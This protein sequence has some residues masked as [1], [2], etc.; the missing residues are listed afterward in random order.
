MKEH[1]DNSAE[2]VT[3]ISEVTDKMHG[4]LMD[5][6]DALM[7]C[8]EGSPEEAELA[9][10]ADVIET[11]ETRRWPLGKVR[12]GKDWSLPSER[13]LVRGL[14]QKASLKVTQQK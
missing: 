11:Y 8:V 1:A 12:G 4:L 6:A 10:L 9:A 5:R 2:A 3:R 13:E 14:R 7:G